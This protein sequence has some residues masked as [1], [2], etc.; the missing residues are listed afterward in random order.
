MYQCRLSNRQ[1]DEPF[2]QALAK[3]SEDIH[4]L[5]LING[6]VL[7]EL[8]ESEENLIPDKIMNY[9]ASNIAD[10][11]ILANL[12]NLLNQPTKIHNHPYSILNYINLS[13]IDAKIGSTLNP[14]VSFTFTSLQLA[15]L[16]NH[17]YCLDMLQYLSPQV[18][19]TLAWFFREL[20]Q[21]YLYMNESSYTFISPVLHQFFGPDTNSAFSILNFLIRKT[22]INLYIWS[23]ENTCSTQ[24]AKLLIDIC[25][26]R[27]MAQYLIQNQNFWSIGHVVTHNHEQ[28]WISL[29]SGVKKMVIKSLIISCLG[30]F[31]ENILNILQILNS[32]FEELN[33]NS[34]S[35]HSETKVN[36]VLNLVECLNGII[37]ATDKENLNFLISIIL[38]KL[39]QSVHLLDRYHNY[40]EVVEL[41][42]SMYHGVI[43]KI[44]TQL[45]NNVNEH[46]SFK[47]KILESFL[48]LIQTFAKHNQSKYS[49][50]IFF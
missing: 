39:E 10:A 35:Y 14:I 47:N 15:E 48:G 26:N 16:E 36:E 44:L 41:I 9:Q 4:W 7:F 3:L 43:E 22:L 2:K 37:E 5:L 17:M 8:N 33:F 6:F 46:M 27:S 28:P 49:F 34:N 13:L 21:S 32:R 38:P 50:R 12:S 45:N 42:I 24:T 30:Q 20:C 19:S 40:G 18:G 31:N 1:V 23:S 25:K 11:N 29:T